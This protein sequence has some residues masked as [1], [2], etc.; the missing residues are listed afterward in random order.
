MRHDGF[1]EG[2]GE[3]FGGALSLELT[4]VLGVVVGQREACDGDE[5]KAVDLQTVAPDHHP[6]LAGGGDAYR[7][8]LVAPE[9]VGLREEGVPEALQVV[10]VAI[11]QHGDVLGA[12]A[13]AS[14][15]IALG[16]V[17]IVGIGDPTVLLLLVVVVGHV[18]VELVAVAAVAGED[19]VAGI[20]APIIGIVAEGIAVVEVHAEVEPATEV[21]AE[22]GCQHVL[23]LVGGEVL[24]IAHQGKGRLGVVEAHLARCVEHAVVA[25]D[26]EE[27]ADALRAVEEVLALPERTHIPLI[28]DS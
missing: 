17:D 25:I 2:L 26:V 28:A 8:A 13:R 11:Q 6:R 22:V 27:V 1:A 16:V 21:D 3:G 23:C 12:D 19:A 14:V 7:A 18:G 9:A 10:Q 5:D 15:G 24:L 20:L 4:A